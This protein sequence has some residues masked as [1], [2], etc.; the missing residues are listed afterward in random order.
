M[1]KLKVVKE[2]IN[3]LNMYEHNKNENDISIQINLKIHTTD[4][5]KNNKIYFNF[6]PDF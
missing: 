1:H 3:P 2:H 6:Y 5:K 4:Q